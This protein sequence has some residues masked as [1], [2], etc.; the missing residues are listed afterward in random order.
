M[1]TA[2][3]PQAQ[4]GSRNAF[5][6]GRK[7]R[8]AL[9]ERGLENL[10]LDDHKIEIHGNGLHYIIQI[11]AACA[12][13]SILAIANNSGMQC[14][15]RER[16]HGR[17][18]LPDIWQINAIE[19]VLV[20]RQKDARRTFIGRIKAKFLAFLGK[21][22][23]EEVAGATEVQAHMRMLI[24]M[25]LHKPRKGISQTNAELLIELSR[26][27]LMHRFAFLNLAARELPISGPRLAFGT[28]SE[29]HS[30]VFADQHADSNINN[31]VFTHDAFPLSF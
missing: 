2:I 6:I 15:F 25:F 30:A 17:A 20:N 4:I 26:K 7:T 9:P 22:L 12:Y 1:S 23:A 18:V 21:S 13:K 28:G 27:R 19:N 10:R 14:I 5:D 16:Q 29:K 31:L 11:A 3:L 8:L 24:T